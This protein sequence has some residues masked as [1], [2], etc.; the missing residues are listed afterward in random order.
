MA[1]GKNNMEGARRQD[2]VG[3]FSIRIVSAVLGGISVVA[4]AGPRIA[5]SCLL[6]WLVS[7]A[8]AWASRIAISTGF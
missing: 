3:G 8:L 7:F 5:E 2:K 4:M 1:D 6:S